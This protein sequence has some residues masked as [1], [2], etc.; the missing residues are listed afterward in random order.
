[1]PQHPSVA[2]PAVV[3][4]APAKLNLDLHV[5]ARR[6]DGYHEID[7]LV[8]FTAFGDRLEASPAKEL[9]L[10]VEG[11][12]ARATPRGAANIVI[13]AAL[14]LRAATG[15][16]AG[17]HLTL[18]KEIP[19]AAGLGG[20]SADA[21]ATLRA[22][23]R[24]W[25][26]GRGAEGLDGLAQGLGAD[27]PACLAS[28]P[29]R[30]RGVGE[31]VE[32]LIGLGGSA[33]LLVN[34]GVELATRAVFAERRPSEGGSRPVSC[35]PGRDLAAG[36]NDLEPAAIRLVPAIREVLEALRAQPGCQ[37]ARMSG[38]GAT[39][40]AL[41]DDAAA[42]SAAAASL[43]LARPGWWLRATMTGASP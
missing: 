20:G 2:E 7:S 36:R 19:V 9:E 8:V 17:A 10:A 28:A 12:F 1:M 41:F 33:V 35:R 42:T 14:A 22:L 39:C 24:L 43:Q 32:P 27:V 37:F 30:A 26:I 16:E 31:R 3:E 21:A 18:V 23:A 11:P 34:P 13:R 4:A 15:I 25:R 6:A 38:S 5:L 40:F 29:V